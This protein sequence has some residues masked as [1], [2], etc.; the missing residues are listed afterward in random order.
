MNDRTFISKNDSLS[1]INIQIVTRHV[2][3]E[4]MED[5]DDHNKYENM[6]EILSFAA[7]DF[8]IMIPVLHGHCLWKVLCL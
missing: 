8:A 1:D 6:N 3:K 4:Y 2:D 5:D 7:S